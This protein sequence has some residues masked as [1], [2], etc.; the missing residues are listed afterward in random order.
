MTVSNQ[1]DPKCPECGGSGVILIK[2]PP[3]EIL[4]KIYGKAVTGAFPCRCK[5]RKSLSAWLLPI[6]M[7]FGI[8]WWKETKIPN[9]ALEVNKNQWI[10]GNFMTS[11][12]VV[13]NSLKAHVAKKG[14]PGGVI[15][16]RLMTDEEFAKWHFKSN[17]EQHDLD[18]V[19]WSLIK[20]LV[21]LY[22]SRDLPTKG[23]IPRALASH[24]TRV[25][26][27]GGR[28]WIIYHGNDVFDE[29]NLY[30]EALD[31]AI[32][33]LKFEKVRVSSETKDSVNRIPP[34]PPQTP[35]STTPKKSSGNSI[36]SPGNG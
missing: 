8:G 3:P 21:V 7:M 34:T 29:S 26:N 10:T 25:N 4:S 28:A 17:K 13:R 33:L 12:A 24:I 31:T 6:D 2:Q 36:F 18:S 9:V 1:G 27:L 19:N 35:S 23:I 30:D 32:R 20:L 11:L 15:D 22:G 14:F 5:M 16:Y